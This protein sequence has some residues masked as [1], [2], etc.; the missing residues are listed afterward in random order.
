M[1]KS[2][3]IDSVAQASGATKAQTAKVID[4]TL[5]TIIKTLSEGDK[6]ILTGF[7]TFEVRDRAARPGI[8]LQ[9]G[10]RITIPATKVPY[11][12]AGKQLKDSVK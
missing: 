5:K 10:K 3:F 6:V 7:G 12:K 8:N 2:E 1:N 4:A 9:T 11:F